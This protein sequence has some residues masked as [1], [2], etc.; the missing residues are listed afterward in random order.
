MPRPCKVRRVNCNPQAMSF[1]PCGIQKN[2]VA[3]VSLNLDELE[4][5]R[6]ADYDG[7]YQEQ[8]AEKMK[9]SRHILFTLILTDS[10]ILNRLLCAV[11][12]EFPPQFVR[13][14]DS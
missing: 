2:S 5:I 10:P 3:T 14:R 12:F 9:I 4:A 6:L 1:K 8:A 7:L 11:Y 13:A